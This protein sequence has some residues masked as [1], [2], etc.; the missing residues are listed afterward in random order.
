MKENAKNT[1]RKQ[2]SEYLEIND[3]RKTPERFAVLEAIFELPP[4]FNLAELNEELEKKNFHVSRTTLYNAMKM[5]QKLHFVFPHK[6]ASGTY[7]ESTFGNANRCCQVCT[8]CG[9]ITVVRSAPIVRAVEEIK[10]RRFRKENFSLYI[11]GICSNC[12][13][14]MTRFKN[15]NKIL[16]SDE[17]R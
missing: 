11:F 7:Y 10:L 6:F 3:L 9:S 16:Q 17:Q 4:Y 2:F 1:V 15:K 12:Q 5:F 8:V 13:A 14:K